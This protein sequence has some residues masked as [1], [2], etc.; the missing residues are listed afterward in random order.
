MSMQKVQEFHEAFGCGVNAAPTVLD[1]GMGGTAPLNTVADEM[2]KLAGY[3]KWNAKT[4]NFSNRSEEGLA[5]IRA[6]L[7][8]EEL[9]EV[10]REMANAG[11]LATILHE[12]TDLEYVVKGTFL[13]YGLQEVRPAAFLRV[14]AANMSKLDKDGKPIIDPSGR[15][16]KSKFFQPA[17]LTDL[18][19]GN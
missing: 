16:V 6:Q 11:D 15:T 13:S 5:L 14:H 10:I 3:L 9:G 1:V 2:G 12:L 19:N 7:M 4:A 8:V 17:D 18:I